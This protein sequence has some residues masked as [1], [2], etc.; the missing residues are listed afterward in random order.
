MRERYDEEELKR[1]ILWVGDAPDF[2]A[3]YDSLPQRPYNRLSEV[4]DE[5]WVLMT[6]TRAM[7]RTTELALDERVGNISIGNSYGN[8]NAILINYTREKSREEYISEKLRERRQQS[9]QGNYK[10][11]LFRVLWLRN[12]SSIRNIYV[13]LLL[14]HKISEEDFADLVQARDVEVDLMTLCWWQPQERQNY[15]I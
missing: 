4:I 8:W 14:E 11:Y 12:Q 13:K 15:F 2:G 5:W 9:T 1:I 3:Q 10:W 6:L 7:E